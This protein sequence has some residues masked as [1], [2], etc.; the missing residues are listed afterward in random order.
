MLFIE[1]LWGVSWQQNVQ[2]AM[3][4]KYEFSIV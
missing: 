4:L 3:H 2:E 1:T